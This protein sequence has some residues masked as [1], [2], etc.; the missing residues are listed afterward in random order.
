MCLIICS[1]SGLFLFFGFGVFLI[2][3]LSTVLAASDP[4]AAQGG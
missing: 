2:M 1:V 3:V 4:S